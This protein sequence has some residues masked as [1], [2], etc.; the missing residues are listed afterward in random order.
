MAAEQDIT[1]TL[2]ADMNIQSNQLNTEK[3]YQNF[4][5]KVGEVLY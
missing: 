4:G 3:D 5:K 1:E 2:F